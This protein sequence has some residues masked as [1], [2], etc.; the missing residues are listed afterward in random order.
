MAHLIL[1]PVKAT[2]F[3]LLSRAYLQS[4]S[5]INTLLPVEY[6]CSSFHLSSSFII[7]L[8]SLSHQG[9]AGPSVLTTRL[10]RWGCSY[11]LFFWSLTVYTH[12]KILPMALIIFYQF[13]LNLQGRRQIWIKT[14]EFWYCKQGNC[15]HTC[16]HICHWILFQ[17]RSESNERFAMRASWVGKE[18]CFFNCD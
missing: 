16:L 9:L 3:L 14:V 18:W 7:S 5:H 17:S 15:S 13:G 11:V 6:K 2:H 8:F 1:V 12:K 4:I 10:P